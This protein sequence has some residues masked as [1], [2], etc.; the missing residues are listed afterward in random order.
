MRQFQRGLLPLTPKICQRQL[1]RS[2]RGYRETETHQRPRTQ[3]RRTRRRA[4]SWSGPGVGF[5]SRG[6]R[7]DDREG[8]PDPRAC[9]G[10]DGCRGEAGGRG[11]PCRGT[12][13]GR[14]DD[15]R[16]AGGAG[17]TLARARFDDRAGCADPERCRGRSRRCGRN[18]SACTPRSR[19]CADGSGR[20][21]RVGARAASN[22]ST[23]RSGSSTT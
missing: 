2:L 3:P 6:R 23:A 11:D 18:S 15:R 5:T 19:A 9:G 21:R 7:G 12:R 20:A 4:P 16:G 22:R 17:R 13:H 14:E 1:P 10:R 8:A